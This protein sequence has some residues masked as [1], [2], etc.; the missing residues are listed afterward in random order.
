MLIFVF[1]IRPARIFWNSTHCLLNPFMLDWSRNLLHNQMWNIAVNN[2][3]YSIYLPST[4]IE[5]V[6]TT[7]MI[8]FF[9]C[10]V[11]YTTAY[12][13]EIL[14]KFILNIMK[15]YFPCTLKYKVC[16]I[17]KFLSLYSNL[18]G[19]GLYTNFEGSV[20]FSFWNIFVLLWKM[21]Y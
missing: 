16:H 20:N 6:Y 8:P 1:T 3:S 7:K 21:I 17:V 10:S 13:H 5:K 11:Y 9:F 14:N 18:E 19:L 15:K 4:K 2:N 12:V